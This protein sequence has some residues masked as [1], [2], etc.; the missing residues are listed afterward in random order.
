[1]TEAEWLA[2]TDPKSM[3][4]FLRGKASDRKLRLFACACC[5][6][7]WHQLEQW[8][9]PPMAA[10]MEETVRRAELYADGHTTR[11]EMLQAQAGWDAS[12]YE[13]GYAFYDCAG[14]RAE[15]LEV[16]ARVAHALTEL[17]LPIEPERAAQVD[18]LR[19]VIGNPFRRPPKLNRSW[20]GRKDSAVRRLAQT[21]YDDR[22][23]PAGSLDPSHLAVLADALE[24]AGCDNAEM[25]GHL[26]GPE[27]HVRGCWAVD[28]LLG[29][30]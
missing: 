23:L 16:P 10:S 18:L 19:E 14:K 30:E 4:K 6:R 20:L 29:R 25:L 2:C 12:G 9:D 24:D 7:A 3:L 26:R 28:L 13:L 21:A 22:T 1:M 8:F 15:L 11:D 27:V 5:R 17:E